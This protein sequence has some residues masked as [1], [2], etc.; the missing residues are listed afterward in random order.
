VKC[1]NC[2]EDL[3]PGA[4]TVTAEGSVVCGYCRSTKT[5]VAVDIIEAIASGEVHR[6]ECIASGEAMHLRS[7][8]SGDGRMTC[9]LRELARYIETKEHVAMLAARKDRL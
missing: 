6:G 2:S 3:T 4:A 9:F 1:A 8:I 7:F 5:S